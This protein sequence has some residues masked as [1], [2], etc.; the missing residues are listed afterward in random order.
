MAVLALVALGALLGTVEDPNR[1]GPQGPEGDVRISACEVDATTKWPH[2]ELIVT[3]RSSRPS[4]YL[5]SVEFLD[6]DGVRL[7]EAHAVLTRVGPDQ[8]ARETAQTLTQVDV[9]VTCR[10]TDVTRTASL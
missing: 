1:D 10:L 8:V 5:V 7:S 9:P 6:P 4:D 3:N 2:A